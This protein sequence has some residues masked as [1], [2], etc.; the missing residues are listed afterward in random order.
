M[1]EIWQDIKNY[2]GLYQISDKGNVK[3]LKREKILTP[4]KNSNGYLRVQLTKE[5]VKNR[6]FVHRLVAEAFNPNPNKYPIVN[7]LDCNP[8][9]NDFKNLEWCTLKMN[10][11]YMCK[12]K[13]NVRTKEWLENLHI[14]AHNQYKPVLC[15]NTQKEIIK[16][17]ECIQDVKFDGFDVGCVCLCAQNKRKTHKGYEWA[18]KEAWGVKGE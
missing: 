5:G 7:H 15:I 2:E 14:S 18:Y 10:S 9:N 3:S 1:E 8:L 13:R 6:F 4:Q 17:Y 12:L 16:E 11:E